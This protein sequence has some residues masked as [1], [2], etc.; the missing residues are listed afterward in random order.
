MPAIPTIRKQLP[1]EDELEANIEEVDD[2]GEKGFRAKG[3][4]T[5]KGKDAK[6]KAL[7]Q[8]RKMKKAGKKAD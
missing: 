4:F 6:K 3:G 7:E 2:K 1:F 5:F 8:A